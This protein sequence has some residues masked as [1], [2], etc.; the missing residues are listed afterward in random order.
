M[1]ELKKVDAPDSITVYDNT[2][3]TSITNEVLTKVSP[4]VRLLLDPLAYALGAISTIE[5]QLKTAK[6]P[7]RIA[8]LTTK[9]NQWKITASI[10]QENRNDEK[11]T[12]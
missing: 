4:S 11:G 5:D 2:E 1:D 12:I 9:L 8:K 7:K 3:G 6:S 10:I